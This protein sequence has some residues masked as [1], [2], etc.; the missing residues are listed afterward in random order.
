MDSVS[1]N[2]CIPSASQCRS[3]HC[4]RNGLKKALKPVAS[5]HA[6][7]LSDLNSAEDE[8]ERF[9]PS[10]Q[11]PVSRANVVKGYEIARNQYVSF[12]QAALKALEDE[13]NEHAEI[14]EFVPVDAVDAVYFEKTYYLGPDKGGE[15]PYRLLARALS[16]AGRGAIAKVVMRGRK[17]WC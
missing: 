3:L 7:Q 17:R 2:S 6:P 12:T 4:P 5:E 10:R 14:Q 8:P 15:K 9:V 11:Q 13:A 1:T 16:Q